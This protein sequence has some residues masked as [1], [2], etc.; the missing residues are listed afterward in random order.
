MKTQIYITDHPLNYFDLSQCDY[1]LFPKP[2]T[3]MNEAFCPFK[4][5]FITFIKEDSFR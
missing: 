3:V 1:F 5:S 2:R 4:Q